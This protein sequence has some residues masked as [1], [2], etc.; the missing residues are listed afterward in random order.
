MSG[1]FRGAS[2]DWDP[3]APVAVGRAGVAVRNYVAQDGLFRSYWDTDWPYARQL[4]TGSEGDRPGDMKFQFGG[5][6]FRLLNGP[7]AADDQNHYVIY[8]SMQAIIPMGTSMGN[9]TMPPFRG[10]GGGPDGGP[11]LTLKGQDIDLF[12]T[13]T[14]VRPGEI[15]EVGDT[16]T[17][18]GLMWP[19]L[20]AKGT[21]SVTTPSNTVHTF[22]G[23]ANKVGY[24]YAP[25][26]DFTITEPGV[27]TVSVALVF[28]GETSAGQV[29]PPY[30]TGDV[31]GS[32]NGTFHFYAADYRALQR[33]TN[34]VWED[35]CKRGSC[36]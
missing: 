10:N 24:F 3:V 7:G 21:V 20:D 2:Q 25:G 4:G 13:P 31:L 16:F 15:L 12:I 1:E 6:V 27:Y 22:S 33:V 34:Y 29:V 30:P 36:C 23:Q 35:C 14:G 19:N 8:S 32:D 9:R 11:L 28:D 17:F 26:G 5:G 18:A